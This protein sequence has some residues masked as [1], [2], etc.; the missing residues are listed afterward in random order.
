[1][2]AKKIFFTIL[3]VVMVI[4]LIALIFFKVSSSF[5]D[6]N[7]SIEKRIGD[8]N[9]GGSITML[10]YKYIIEK[11]IGPYLKELR[12]KN[13]EKAYSY[14]TPEYNEY[15]SYEEF[16][17]KISKFDFS[18]YS[19]ESLVNL[20]QN[21]Y[22]IKLKFSDEL[23][24]PFLIIIGEKNSTITP[25]NFITYSKVGESIEKRSVNYIVNGYKV[26]VDKCLFDIT[27]ENKS[28]S[29]VKISSASMTSTKDGIYNAENASF[30]VAPNQKLDFEIEFD[31][32]ITFPKTFSIEKT[33]EDRV[34]TYEFKL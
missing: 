7:Y 31:A 1:M 2:K 8:K 17:E 11:T 29:D 28:K 23:T 6:E 22:M 26:T 21:M 27:I 12:E 20:T 5:L 3:F 32:S 19:V 9:T 25:D 34:L 15:V 10:D 16:V 30:S 14:N 13:Y 18:T 4:S 33:E 24:Q